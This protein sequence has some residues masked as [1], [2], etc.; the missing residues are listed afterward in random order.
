MS[1]FHLQDPTSVLVIGFI[2]GSYIASR[3]TELTARLESC[4]RFE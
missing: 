2:D 1:P 3:K 4:G